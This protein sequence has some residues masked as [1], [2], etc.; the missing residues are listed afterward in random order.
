MKIKANRI[1]EKIIAAGMKK[2]A[3]K[4]SRI[5]AGKWSVAGVSVLRRGIDEI[6]SG[7][8]A[9]PGIRTVVYFEISGKHP[10][11]A[12]V[13][14]RPED[15]ALISRVYPGGSS[16]RLKAIKQ[17]PEI[18]FPEL[19]NVILNSFIGCLFDALSGSFLPAAPKCVRGEPQYLLEAVWMTLNPEQ[20][21]NVAT[22]TLNLACG[23]GEARVEVIAV[24]SESLEK[25]LVSSG[26]K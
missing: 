1:L 4:L 23:G 8:G 24:I 19:G 11:T 25:A 18:L 7:Q 14:F 13:V 5:A 15:I 20:Q 12:M 26:K 17:T 2:C 22:V 9:A 10:F 21:H 16:P 6:L 3:A